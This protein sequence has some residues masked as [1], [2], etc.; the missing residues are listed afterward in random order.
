VTTIGVNNTPPRT[1]EQK[2]KD[3]MVREVSIILALS[4][5]WSSIGGE[6]VAN[7]AGRAAPNETERTQF[8]AASEKQNAVGD[9]AGRAA[10]NEAERT[11]FVAASEGQ[12]ASVAVHLLS[13][14][15]CSRTM[16]QGLSRLG[17][18]VR[19]VDLRTGYALVYAS[20]G[21]L[22]DILDLEGIAYAYTSGSDED[23]SDLRDP[24]ISVPLS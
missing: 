13:I 20:K 23:W 24:E 9:C 17:A 16:L 21:T 14:E 11:Q 4:L 6:R 5:S 10:L 8:V 1:Y 7:C 15:G 22:A 2:G 3:A 18:T 12:R 19:Y